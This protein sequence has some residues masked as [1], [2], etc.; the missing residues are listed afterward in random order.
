[1]KSELLSLIDEIKSNTKQ[2]SVNKIDEVKVMKS[3]LNDKNFRLG[4]YDKNEGYI[5]EHCPAEEATIFVKNIIQ[6]ATGLDA[7]DSMH[8]AES[9]EFTKKDA[10]FMLSNMRDFIDIYMQSGRKLNIIQNQTTE[11]NIYTREMGST[12]KIVPDKETGKPK[13]ISTVPFT[14]LVSISR[15]PK[16]ASNQTT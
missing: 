4:I 5:G 11:A 10:T 9:Y 13:K 7:R 14:K 15:C 6:G 8:L 1:M 12:T 2:I 3:M 16:Y